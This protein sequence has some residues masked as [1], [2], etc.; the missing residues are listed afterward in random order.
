[1]SVRR[2]HLPDARL[3]GVAMMLAVSS[4]AGAQQINTGTPP[5]P[6]GSQSPIGRSATTQYVS[7]AQTFTVSPDLAPNLTQFQFWVSNTVDFPNIQYHAYVF[8]WNEATLRPTG[9][10]LYRSEART[11]VSDGGPVLQTFTTGGLALTSGQMYAAIL[12]SVE[13]GT[14][15]ERTLGGIRNSTGGVAGTYAG[16]AGYARFSL[17]T[18]GLTGLTNGAWSAAG[19]NPGSD[20]AFTANFAAAQTP[21]VVPEPTTVAL[22]GTGLFGLAVGTVRRRRG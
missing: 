12:S 11:G 13:F 16:G 22:L 1:M 8:A 5:N 4:A 7:A 17:N 10:Y 19:G 14:P 9:S 3:L 18:D 21:T 15:V 6:I 20:F 2:G